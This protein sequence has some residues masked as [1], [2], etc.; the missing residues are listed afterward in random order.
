MALGTH[1]AAPALSA[2]EPF[3][4][5]D[6]GCTGFDPKSGQFIVGHRRPVAAA[7]TGYLDTRGHPSYVWTQQAILNGPGIRVPLMGACGQKDGTFLSGADLKGRRPL[8]A[9]NTAPVADSQR[10]LTRPAV[11]TRARADSQRQ[12]PAFLPLIFCSLPHPKGLWPPMPLNGRPGLC[13]N[14]QVRRKDSP[15]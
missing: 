9:V 8:P 3:G 13:N 10:P 6:Q 15:A 2:D 4:Q 12:W 1:A 7:Q 14:S 5:R 11:Q